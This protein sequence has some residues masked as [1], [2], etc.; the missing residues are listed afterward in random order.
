[1]IRRLVLFLI[2]QNKCLQPGPRDIR[3]MLD[4]LR[5]S[6]V[7]QTLIGPLI[8]RGTTQVE[9]YRFYPLLIVR[10][11]VFQ[12]SSS[13]SLDA[14]NLHTGGSWTQRGRGCASVILPHTLNPLYGTKKGV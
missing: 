14:F 9:K 3:E 7:L 10:W 12:H 1:M 5:N 2:S 11:S 6:S 13:H 4:G 8:S